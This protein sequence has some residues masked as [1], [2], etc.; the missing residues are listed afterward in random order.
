MAE[1]ASGPLQKTRWRPALL[2]ALA[3]CVATTIV[4]YF[5][6]SSAQRG[7]QS[8]FERRAGSIA[9]GLQST[10]QRAQDRLDALAGALASNE[11]LS[12]AEF[13]IAA[14]A[15]RP[16]PGEVFI[17]WLPRIAASDRP[18]YDA[19]VRLRHPESVGLFEFDERG[20]K[21]AAWNRPDFHPVD[22][23]TPEAAAGALRGFDVASI[24]EVLYA[25]LRARE[26][27]T[28]VVSALV[29][30]PG[31]PKETEKVWC[32]LR[33]VFDVAGQERGMVF[34]VIRPGQMLDEIAK[35]WL[36]SGHLRVV[37]RGDNDDARAAI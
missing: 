23:L 13:T 20:S 22:R 18:A 31:L 16:L 28:A 24:K 30:F 3:G 2:V 21:I 8:S 32:M 37:L 19:D 6:Q 7:E 12:D 35:P 26:R 9:A 17:A 25:M 14:N 27:R 36:I 33:P 15:T 34:S 10:L 29:Q 5:A 4:F 1:A 11:K